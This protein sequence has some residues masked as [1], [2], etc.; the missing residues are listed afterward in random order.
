MYHV[1]WHGLKWSTNQGCWWFCRNKWGE[2]TFQ[3]MYLWAI[4]WYFDTELIHSPMFLIPWA[5][6]WC[7]LQLLWLAQDEATN[8]HIMLSAF[9]IFPPPV[10]GCSVWQDDSLGVSLMYSP[11]LFHWQAQHYFIKNLSW[12]LS[13][14]LSTRA[15]RFMISVLADVLQICSGC[16][17]QLRRC[18]NAKLDLCLIIRFARYSMFSSCGLDLYMSHLQSWCFLPCWRTYS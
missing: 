4:I 11:S 18:R 10:L 7:W 9:Y 2:N 14:L 15:V 5:E 12:G 16:A 8:E 1:S 6:N 17:V 13:V 3:S